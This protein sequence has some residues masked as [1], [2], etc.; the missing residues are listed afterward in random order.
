MSRLDALLTLA[1]QSPDDTDLMYMLGHELV[2]AGRDAEALE[3]LGRYVE[4]GRDTG[5]A[6]GLIARIHAKDD[7]L[8][9]AR[10]CL[11]QGIRNAT[12]CGHPSMAAELREQLAL[13]DED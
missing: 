5:A 6:W 7:R 12:Q 10:L 4:R 13:L 11:E 8:D 3:W 9:E 1:A 2:Q